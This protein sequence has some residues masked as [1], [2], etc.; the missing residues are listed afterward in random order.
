MNPAARDRLLNPFTAFE[1]EATLPLLV[2][3]VAPLVLAPLVLRFGRRW[4]SPETRRDAWRR[5]RGWL[6]IVP[7]MAAAV[8]LG[9]AWVIAGVA[10]LSL[11]SFREY[12]RATG[13]F[14]EKFIC[15]LVVLGVGVAHFAALD[16]WYRLFVATFPLSIACVAGF[17]AAQDRPKGYLQRVALGMVAFSLFGSCLGHLSFL[18]NDVDY[19]PRLAV[20]LIAVGYWDVAR[21]VVG[22]AVGGPKLVPHTHPDRT[23]SGAVAGAVV[24]VG[25][26]VV[27]GWFAFARTG[28]QDSTRL[29][30]FG[31]LV[32]A[33]AQFGDLMLA[34]I[35]RDTGV[36]NL[37]VIIPGHGGLLD[38]FDSLILV[39]PVAFHVI[40]YYAGVGVDQPVCIFTGAR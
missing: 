33:A 27:A 19:R 7:T 22:R 14:R 16:N 11:L 25:F 21:Y 6:V 37:D 4:V 36:E 35:K 29:A 15:Y 31:L 12:A 18:A 38:R 26:V 8:L 9:A 1:H 39:A 30:A 32:A 17:A 23:V 34:A 10:V 24:V 3:A 5:Y 20:V 28:L 13:L 2:A 40:N